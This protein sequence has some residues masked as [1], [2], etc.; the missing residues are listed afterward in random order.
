MG[1]ENVVGGLSLSATSSC[2]LYIYQGILMADT[3]TPTHTHMACEEHHLAAAKHVAAAYH[4]FQ[5]VAEINKGNHQAANTHI[6]AATKEG[7]AATSH[8]ATAI[9]H[10]KK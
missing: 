7:S 8:C 1:V 2:C 10:L 6:E 9:G 5:A 3:K 4:H